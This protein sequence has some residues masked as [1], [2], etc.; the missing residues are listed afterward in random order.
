MLPKHL[1]NKLSTIQ[2]NC[3]VEHAPGPQPFRAYQSDKFGHRARQTKQS[4]LDLKLLRRTDCENIAI[5]PTELQLTE[6]GREVVCHILGQYADILV[7]LGCIDLLNK[8]LLTNAIKQAVKWRPKCPV[9]SPAVVTPTE[10]HAPSM[11]SINT[12]QSTDKLLVLLQTGSPAK[13]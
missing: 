8:N 2:R 13:F 7:D 3:L 5:R 9:I 6:S 4:L 12:A 1:A 11:T 10:L